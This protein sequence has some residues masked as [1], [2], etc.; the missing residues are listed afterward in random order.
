M[1]FYW[2]SFLV[3]KRTKETKKVDKCGRTYVPSYIVLLST[4]E[5]G[6]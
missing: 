2:T 4:R 3:A 6:S 5:V 1:E